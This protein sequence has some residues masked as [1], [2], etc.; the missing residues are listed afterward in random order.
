MALLT[1]AIGALFISGAG[2]AFSMAGTVRLLP[3]NGTG[4][5][6]GLCA[7]GPGR[8]CSGCLPP[9]IAGVEC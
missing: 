8:A 9:I 6:F 1:G 3:I 5:V 7:Y 2:L 4:L